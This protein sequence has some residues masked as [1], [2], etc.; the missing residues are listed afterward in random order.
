MAI[1]LLVISVMGSDRGQDVAVKCPK[2]VFFLEIKIQVKEVF[3]VRC[4]DYKVHLC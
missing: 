1:C 2:D 3:D 4:D